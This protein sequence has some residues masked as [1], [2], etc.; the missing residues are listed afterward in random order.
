MQKFEPKIEIE[1]L[2][3]VFQTN[4]FYPTSWRDRFIEI[5]RP[6]YKKSVDEKILSKVSLNIK[7]GDR[8]GILGLNGAG[9]TSLCRCISGI[10]QPSGGQIEVVGQV[11]AIFDTSVALFPELTGRE[12]IEILVSLLYPSLKAQDLVEDICSFSGLR[13]YLDM[14]FKFYSNG[15]KTRLTLSAISCRPSD[16][17]ILDEVFEGADQSFKAKIGRRISKMIEESGIVIFVSHTPSQVLEV[18]NRAIVLFDSEVVLDGSPQDAVS[19]YLSI[20]ED[21]A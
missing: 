8:L 18:C 14:P 5:F 15:M 16:I 17:L 13:K 11:Q 21:N 20:C 6:A 19:E 4:Y 10:Y 12:N 1:N 9:K 3:L 7:S 2:D